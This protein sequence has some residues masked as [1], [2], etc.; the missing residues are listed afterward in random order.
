MRVLSMGTTSWPV[1][2]NGRVSYTVL[3]AYFGATWTKS[4]LMSLRPRA[5]CVIASTRVDG[6][7]LA[8]LDTRPNASA[9]ES[10]WLLSAPKCGVPKKSCGEKGQRGDKTER[11]DEFH[12]TH[13]SAC[14]RS[15]R[16]ILAHVVGVAHCL[17]DN[18]SAQAMSEKNGGTARVQVFSPQLEVD[19]ECF[20][21]PPD[22]GD[23]V[24]LVDVAAVPKR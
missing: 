15:D 12:E 21:V 9:I 16:L 20:G 8:W 4:S 13:K 10:H 2:A 22:A 23:G 18:E 1:S 19:E 14:R 6:L 3:M 7:P 24:I 11:D 17:L 5:F